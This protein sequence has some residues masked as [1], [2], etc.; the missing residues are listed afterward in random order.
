MTS[1]GFDAQ[2]Y[3]EHSGKR[4]AATQAAENG[5]D[6]DSLQ[7]LGGWRSEQMA[8]KYV[9]QSTESKIKLSKMLQ[10]RL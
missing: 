3:G 7:R 9:D 8:A 1:L 2:L 5:M 4:G 6:S 10:K